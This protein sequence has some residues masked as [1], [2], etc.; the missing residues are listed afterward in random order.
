M[1]EE[2]TALDDNG[3]WDLVSC[4]ARKK[5]IGCKWVFS[6]KVN[7]YGIVG[8][9]KA[10]LVSKAYAQTYEHGDIQEEVYIEQPSGFVAQRESDYKVCRLQKSLYG[11]K[12]S[13]REWFGKFS[14]ALVRFGG[15]L[16]SWKSEKQNVV[17]C[18]SAES[19]YKSCDNQVALR[20]ASNPVFHERTKHIEVDCHF[21]RE[22]I[23]DELVSTGYVKTEEQL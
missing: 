14:Q 22:K 10:R 18:S 1:I 2:M 9:L 8:Q 11:L 17:S 3:T 6:V 21:I 23:Q 4:P 12:Q 7:P 19:E 16:V 13:S 5:T 15:N 20:I